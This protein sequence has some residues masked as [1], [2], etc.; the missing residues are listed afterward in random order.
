MLK[1]NDIKRTIEQI[2]IQVIQKHYNVDLSD[3]RVLTYKQIMMANPFGELSA[4]L[5]AFMET[6]INQAVEELTKKPDKESSTES[7][8]NAYNPYW[9]GLGKQYD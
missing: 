3:P 5:T 7:A 2:I 1:L 4:E 9:F 6:I 8:E